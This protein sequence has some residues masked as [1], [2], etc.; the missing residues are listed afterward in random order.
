MKIHKGDTVKIMAGKN[1]GKTGKVLRVLPKND[2][3]VVEGIN[4]YKKHQRPKRQG[5]KGEVVSVV[6]PLPISNA[7][8]VCTNCKKAS[9][10]G[11]RFENDNK[12]RYCKKC[13][14]SL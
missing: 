1:K 6:R 14:G 13:K 2:K 4:I 9:R 5:E 10:A 12:V 7:M 11:Y 8:L 3:I